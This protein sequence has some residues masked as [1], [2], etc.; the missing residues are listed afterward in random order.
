MSSGDGF[1]LF[2]VAEYLRTS[3]DC[4]TCSLLR[5]IFS[6]ADI[7]FI[8]IVGIANVVSKNMSATVKPCG[9]Q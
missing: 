8:I 7:M 3:T 4:L 5:F 1:A 6:I 9:C 2:A